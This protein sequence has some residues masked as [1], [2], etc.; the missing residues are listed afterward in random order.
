[1]ILKEWNP[2]NRK[3]TDRKITRVVTYVV[4]TKDIYF[5]RTEDIG[6]HGLQIIGIK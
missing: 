6:K 5:W 2:K 4:K 3:Y 1:M